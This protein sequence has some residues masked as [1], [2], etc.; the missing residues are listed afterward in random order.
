MYAPHCS[1][2]FMNYDKSGEFISIPDNY[3]VYTKKDKAEP[4]DASENEEEP[5]NQELEEG[6]KMVRD[7]QEFQ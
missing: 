5:S 6:V 4:V 2:G 1:L 3:V 7:L